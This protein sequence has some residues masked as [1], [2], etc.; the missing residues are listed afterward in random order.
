MYR[1]I[2]SNVNLGG[3]VPADNDLSERYQKLLEEFQTTEAEL[4]KVKRA[5]E[6]KEIELKAVLAQAHEVSNTDALTFLPNRRKIIVDLQEEVIR[7]N[8]YNTPLS[9]SILDIDHFKKVN[10]TYGHTTGDETLRN[11]A[12]RLR[13]QIRHPD[14]IGRYGGEEFLIVLPNSELKA[15]SEQASRLCQRVRAMQVEANEHVLSVTVSIGVAQYR[16]GE[17]NWDQLLNRADAALY[18]AK[19]NGRD[20]WVVA[21]D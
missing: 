13:E 19:N 21:E 18:R 17:E 9:I 14:T 20:R 11:V 2:C 12:A 4:Q 5:L 1:S 7:S 6:I 8:R 16:I 3:A 10:D 15:A